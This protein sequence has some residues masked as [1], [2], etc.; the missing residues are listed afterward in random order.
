MSEEQ[1]HG[2]EGIKGLVSALYKTIN[3]IDDV[4]DDNRITLSDIQHLGDLMELPKDLSN[5]KKA[6]PEA[7]E[8]S[9]EE[10]QEVLQ[11]SISEAEE[12]FDEDD[13]NLEK[14]AVAIMNA[15]MNMSRAATLIKQAFTK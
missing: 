13:E 3:T 2:T 11:H 5:L 9:V 10:Q 4:F 12:I 14:V 6:G 1:K 8:L 7:L 15:A